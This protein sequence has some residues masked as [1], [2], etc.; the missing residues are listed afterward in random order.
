MGFTGSY[1]IVKR[2]VR[3]LKSEKARIAY[4]RFETES[5]RQA[6]SSPQCSVNYPCISE[7]A[8]QAAILPSSFGTATSPPKVR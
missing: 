2:H 3:K 5:G 6:Q 1:D 4:L 8:L 7:V